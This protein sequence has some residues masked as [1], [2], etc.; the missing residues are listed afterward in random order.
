MSRRS[1]KNRNIRN[2][3]KSRNTYSINIP[4][5]IVQDLKWQERQKVVVKKSGKKIVITDWKK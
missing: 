2:I 3:Q 5:E 1:L 4:I